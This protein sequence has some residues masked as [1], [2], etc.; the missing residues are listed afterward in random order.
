[1]KH[2]QITYTDGKVEDLGGVKSVDYTINWVVYHMDNGMILRINNSM[3]H[4]IITY[5]EE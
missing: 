5:S 1:M 4:S 3:I 2:H